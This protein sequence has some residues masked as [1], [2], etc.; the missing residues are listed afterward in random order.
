MTSGTYGPPSKGS[1]HSAALSLSLGNRL[2]ERLGALGSI[3]YRLTWRE[4]AT[5]AGRL[6]SRLVASVRP[7]SDKGYTGW[8]TPVKQDSSNARNI[9]TGKRNPGTTLVDA[10]WLARGPAR[11]T[12]TG[13]IL[14]GSSA[15]MENGGQLNPAHSRWLMGLPQEWD[16]CA[17]MGTRSQRKSRKV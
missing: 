3:L 9:P 10:A 6:F 7:T 12:A 4:K 8:P 11:L 15:G 17:P 13:E 16:D 14:T 5:P 2:R 1:S